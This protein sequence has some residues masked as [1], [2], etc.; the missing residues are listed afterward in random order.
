MIS[1]QILFTGMII[2]FLIGRV[3]AKIEV[4]VLSKIVQMQRKKLRNFL[5]KE[6]SKKS[7]KYKV[8]SSY[9][10]ATPRSIKI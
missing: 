3:I 4:A 5:L 10:I 1:L 2:G 6:P 7:L 9:L 8:S